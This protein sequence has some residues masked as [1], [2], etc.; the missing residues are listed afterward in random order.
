MFGRPHF[1]HV[2]PAYFRKIFEAARQDNPQIAA[3]TSEYDITPAARGT[4]YYL[5]GHAGYAIRP[6]GE[7]VYVFSTVKGH[8]DAIV[9]SAIANGATHLDRFDG[10]LPTLYRRNGFHRVT[11]LD[12]WTPG[13]PDVIFMA[14]PGHYDAALAKA[15]S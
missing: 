15:E 6:D 4:R 11:S 12:N 10:Y 9:E 1:S 14:L 13:E 3:A 8:G 2:K 5:S 7:L